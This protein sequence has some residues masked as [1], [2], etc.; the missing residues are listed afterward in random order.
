MTFIP[1][2]PVIEALEVADDA[3]TFAE[4]LLSL[5]VK[6]K[7]VI[8]D[9]QTIDGK[10]V[11]GYQVI[12]NSDTDVFIQ[13]GKYIFVHDGILHIV[14][15]TEAFLELYKK[16]TA[17]RI[18]KPTKKMTKEK[19]VCSQCGYISESQFNECPNCGC[20]SDSC[21]NMQSTSKSCLRSKKK[22]ES[23]MNKNDDLLK[24]RE[25]AMLEES[26]TKEVT[27]VYGDSVS[28]EKVESSNK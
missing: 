19:F 14:E 16:T 20:T 22:K 4:Q 1:I 3:V 5:N 9:R 13:I 11:S 7:S 15:D 26:D 25:E 27:A 18:T 12:S 10:I 21:N 24:A 8:T 23:T 6:F 2:Y 17:K 28:E